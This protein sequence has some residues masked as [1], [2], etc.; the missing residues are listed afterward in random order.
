MA[1]SRD[2]PLARFAAFW[3]GVGVISLFFVILLITRLVVGGDDDANPLE[4]A[5]AMKRLKLRNQVDETQ[6]A[7]LQ[8]QVVEEGETVQAPPMAILDHIG[9]TLLEAEPTKVE[10]PAQIIP[11][12]EAAEELANQPTTTDFGEVDAMSPEAG[13]EP[14]AAVMEAGKAAYALCMACHG[15]QG[16]GVP[17]VGPPLAGS[18]WVE[19]PASNLI[20]IQL[21]GLEGPITVAGEEYTFAAPM[22]PMGAANTDDEVAS[23]LTYIRNSFGNSAPPVLPEQVEALRSEVGKPMLTED[24]LLDPES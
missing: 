17:N 15:P 13:T 21:R 4:Q 1:S 19:G 6:T 11:G 23:V 20:R 3:W 2:N 7:N 10:D 14:D 9:E 8:W 16:A 18:E 5:A 22:A 24:D 12:S